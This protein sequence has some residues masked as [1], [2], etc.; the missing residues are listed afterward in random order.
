VALDA[1]LAGDAG[2][3]SGAATAAGSNAQVVRDLAETLSGGGEDVVIVYPERLV[4]GERGAHAA[5]AL[6]NLAARLGLHGRD[7]AGLLEI[8]SSPNGRGL[9][10]AGFG[11]RSAEGIA[12]GLAG[13]EL[14]TLLLLN[15]DPLRAHPDRGMW[16]AGLKR[17]GTVIAVETV[18]TDTV[19]DHADVVFPGEAYAEKEG[20]LVHPDG[21]LQRLRPGIGRGGR[22]AGWQ[23]ITDFARRAGL[24]LRVL[25]GPMASK[26]LFEAVLQ[27][28]GLTLDEIGGRG[29]RWPERVPAGQPWAPVSLDV[30]AAS[31]GAFKLGR[32][33]PLWASKEVDA[34]P[35][36]Q[37]LRP[38]QM[39]E[40][41]PLDAERLGIADGE[42]V[43]VAQNGH[44]IAGRALLRAAIPAGSVFVA[45]GTHDDPGNVLTGT[46]VQIRGT[47]TKAPEAD[48]QPVIAVPS[49][50]PG[51]EMPDNDPEYT[52]PPPG[53]GFSQSED[54]AR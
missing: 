15:A 46:A 35:A 36:L 50:G 19:R 38:A 14:T 16:E 49:V 53:T 30:P 6:L 21:R 40:L 1:A 43:E 54:G 28:Q 5:R 13:G 29:V 12:A 26:Q 4:S 25:A 51:G 34:S 31:D 37:Y 20:T 33:R 24:D 44:A 3:L 11:G 27:Y 18:M 39:V 10:E 9:R 41:S 47:G 48:A 17:A 2:N 23:V 45:E 42:R 7:G 32:F 22:M 52:Q 8:P